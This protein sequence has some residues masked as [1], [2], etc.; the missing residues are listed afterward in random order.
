[1]PGVSLSVN[2][3]VVAV[4]ATLITLIATLLAGTATSAVGLLAT[5]LAEG[6]QP[7]SHLHPG[8]ED[9]RTF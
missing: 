8:E 1:M 6:E 9:S 5:F 4:F 3:E 2:R 7:S